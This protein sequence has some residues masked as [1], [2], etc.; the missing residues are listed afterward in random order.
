KE[1][2]EKEKLDGVI[3]ATEHF[4]HTDIAK[5]TILH[6]VNTLVEKP[7]A[8]TVSACED[9]IATAA[10]YP[11]VKVGV[12]FNQRSNRLYRRAKR[13]IEDGSL[14]E[15]VRVN[16][17][18]TDW[19]R[20]QAYYNQG[21]WRASY[22]GE[23]G[24]CLLNQCVHQLD[25]LQW[26]IGMPKSVIS[27][28][29]TVNRN[30]TVENDVSA[31]LI[32]DGFNCMFS[33]SSHELKGTNRLE[34]AFD[35][36]KIEITS[37]KMKIWTHRSEK[38]V[39]ATTT[40]GYGFA[41]SVKRTYGYGIWRGIVDIA[42]GQQPRSIRAF[43]DSVRGTGEMLANI[44]EGLNAVELINSIYMAGWQKQAIALPINR[45]EYDRM[46]A[47]RQQEEKNK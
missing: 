11:S 16:F 15:I 34:I 14:G 37:A 30:I 2:L 29:R 17:I 24:G 3:I 25:I 7:L 5:Y 13:I 35:K 47:E 40:F 20:S 31:M 12:S 1:M 28:N 27:D 44:K 36:G 41:P 23:G 26:L 43:A 6:G 19:Y 10:N 38:L 45:A 42:L 22:V 4:A 39:N 18:V 9:I 8:V 32:Y 46:L 21:G 33:A